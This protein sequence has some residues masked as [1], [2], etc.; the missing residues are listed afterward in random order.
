MNITLYRNNSEKN[1]LNKVLTIVENYNNA[2][3]REH[4]TSIEKPVIRFTRSS[5]TG[6]NYV[7]IEEFRRYYFVDDIIII[8]NGMLSLKLSVDVLMSFK[9]QILAQ[10]AIIEKSTNNSN[11]Y[12]RDN[13]WMITAKTKTDIL[14]FSNGFLNSGE[15]ILITA[16][17]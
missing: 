12:L 17:G 3:L 2:T 5:P 4:D 6:F 16:G 1:R 11:Y 9:T 13:N 8:N 10:K 7:F 14:N 15:F